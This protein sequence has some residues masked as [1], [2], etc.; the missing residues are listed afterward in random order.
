MYL[1]ERFLPIICLFFLDLLTI[2]RGLLMFISRHWAQDTLLSQSREA[3]FFKKWYKRGKNHLGI[4]SSQT[5]CVC[6]IKLKPKDFSCWYTS[7]RII[8]FCKTK[9]KLNFVRW[10]KIPYKPCVRK[11]IMHMTAAYALRSSAL[12][13]CLLCPKPTQCHRHV[14]AQ[15][16]FF[17]IVEE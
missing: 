16:G 10:G 11:R 5:I 4:K 7:F 14:H 9:V 1:Q 12:R 15:N 8:C 3:V 17:L 2:L 13:V 6:G